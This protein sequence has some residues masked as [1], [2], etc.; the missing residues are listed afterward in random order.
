MG[1]TQDCHVQSVGTDDVIDETPFSS[2]QS[3]VFQTTN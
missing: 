3:V 2:D 1:R